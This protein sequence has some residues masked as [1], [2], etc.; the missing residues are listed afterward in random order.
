MLVDNAETSWF[1]LGSERADSWS[2]EAQA[3]TLGLRVFAGPR[4]ASVLRRFTARVG[5]Q[6]PA[7]PYWLGPWYQPRRGDERGELERFLRGNVPLTLAQT[8][9]HYLPCGDHEGAEADQRA[10]AALSTRVSP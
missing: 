4:P 10:R 3:T 7:S 1:R 8:Y 5:R 2:L 6:P 9:T